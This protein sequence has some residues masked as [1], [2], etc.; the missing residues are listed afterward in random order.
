ME[1]IVAAVEEWNFELFEKHSSILSGQWFFASSPDAL[2]DVL[3]SGVNPRYIFFPHW[4]WIV[5]TKV[6]LKYDCVCFHMTDLPYGRGGSP[7]QNL[8]VKGHS[9]TYI[10]ALK[11]DD[12]IDTGPV[13]LKKPMSLHGRA[14]EIYRRA[15][16]ISWLMIEE[17][18]SNS[19]MPVP[20]E[21]EV[22]E[23]KRR[24]PEQSLIPRD[25][26]LSQLYDYIRMLDAPSYPKASIEFGNYRFEFEC[27]ELIEDSIKANVRIIVKE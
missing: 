1:Y 4:R 10:S 22:V 7:L 21:G 23:F 2:N 11:M 9:S 12:G 20:Q 27:A 19:Y 8:I 3:S 16:E 18:I 15:A 6:L 13:Y 17:M 14:E 24:T 5:P 26:N 25:I